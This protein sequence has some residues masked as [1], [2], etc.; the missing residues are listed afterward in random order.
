MK[1]LGIDPGYDR[2]GWGIITVSER[3]EVSVLSYGCIQ[4]DK[5]GSLLQ[6]YSQVISE[7]STM[8]AQHKPDEVSL[9]SIFFSK[10]QKTAMHVSEARGVIISTLIPFS[11]PITEYT[12]NQVKLT[13]TGSGAA[14]KKAVEKMVR[15][16][17][18]IAD[19]KIIDDTIDAIAIAFTHSLLRFKPI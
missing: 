6:R 14:D 19:T 8:L 10:N 12:P 4:T 16:Q 9:E 7:M 5:K 3:R 1:I 2:V 17:L 13:V 11:I 18:K 15:M